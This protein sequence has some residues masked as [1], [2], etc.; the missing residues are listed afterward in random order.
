M[1]QRAPS[2]ESARVAAQLKV[3]VG[4]IARRLRQA[5][6]VGDMTLSETSVLARLDREGPAAPGVLANNERVRPQ[7]MGATLA[8]LEQQGLVTR[9]PDVH[10][11]RRVVMTITAAGRAVIADRRSASIQHMA[12]ALDHEF[13]ASERQTLLAVVPLLDRLAQRL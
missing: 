13:S 11:R 10:D 5:H 12:Y 3:A 6:G 8:V 7:A 1:T 9:T 2:R 4:R